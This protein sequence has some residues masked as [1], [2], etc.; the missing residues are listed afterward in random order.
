MFSLGDVIHF[1]SNEAGKDKFHLCISLE[2]HFVFLNS[3]K[4]QIYPGDFVVACSEIPCLTPT[5]SGESIISCTL[6][7]KKSDSDLQ[8]LGAKKV[9]SVSM[10]LMARIA[11]FVRSSP[12]LTED[13]KDAF[14]EAA[15]DW[16]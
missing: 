4:R 16:I 7:M 8:C 9:G 15:G 2:N 6:V 14:C 11:T 12:V 13:E 1:Y 5:P 10:N 3:P